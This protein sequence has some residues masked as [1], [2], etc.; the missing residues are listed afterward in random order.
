MNMG[1]D[2]YAGQQQ[3]KDADMLSASEED[4]A[5]E[6]MKRQLKMLKEENQRKDLALSFLVCR[7]KNLKNT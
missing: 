3:E 7:R 1:L 4:L 2:E 5:P 6:E